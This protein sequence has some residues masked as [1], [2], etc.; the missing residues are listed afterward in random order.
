MAS[1]RM[2]LGKQAIF[3]SDAARLYTARIKLIEISINSQDHNTR[4]V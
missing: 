1:H 3:R 4:K 2:D